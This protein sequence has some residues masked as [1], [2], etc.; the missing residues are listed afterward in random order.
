MDDIGPFNV[1]TN[2]AQQI[3]GRRITQKLVTVANLQPTH[4]DIATVRHIE[5]A[6]DPVGIGG[7]N[8]YITSQFGQS[9]A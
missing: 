5:I 4:R 1:F 7:Q 9:A 3:E 8:A 6:P 2:Y